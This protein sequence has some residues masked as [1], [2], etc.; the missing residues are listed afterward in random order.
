MRLVSVWCS[1]GVA[2]CFGMWFRCLLLLLLVGRCL[3]LCWCMYG[4]WVMHGKAAFVIRSLQI[5]VFCVHGHYLLRLTL[6]RQ[7]IDP[8][9]LYILGGLHHP[10]SCF[11][12]IVNFAAPVCLFRSSVFLLHGELNTQLNICSPHCFH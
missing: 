7:S 4:R 2:F 8:F 10:A 6:F 11:S 1:V 3:L 12:G 5:V 9:I